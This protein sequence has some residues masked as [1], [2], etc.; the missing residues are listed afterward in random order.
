M[1]N[2]AK[3]TMIL[4]VAGLVLSL[5]VHSASAQQQG[6]FDPQ[7]MARDLPSQPFVGITTDGKPQTGLFGIKPTGVSTAP[8]IE[9]AEAFLAS[10]TAE[11]RAKTLFPIDHTEWR[12]WANVH[13]FKRQGVSLQEM[14]KTQRQSAYD[15]L[16]V[17]LSARGYE[18]SRDIMK[19][20]HHLAELVS[21]FDEYGE[22]LYWFTLMGEPSDKEPWGWQIDGHHLIVNYFVLGDQVVMT[23]TFM[24]SEPVK[25]LSGD[26]AGISIL[27][28]EQQ[29]ALTLMQA[30]PL[31]QQQQALLGDKQGRSENTAE[32]FKDNL[33]L[34]AEGLPAESMGETHRAML[35]DIIRLFVG[36]IGDGHA[37]VKMDEVIAHLDDTHF[38][39]KGGIEADAVF[40]YRIQ[41]P[42]ILVEFDH[43]GPIALDGPRAVPTRR[44][45][46]TVV[47]TPN[48][49]DYGKDLLRQHYADHAHDP[50]HGHR[51]PA[52]Q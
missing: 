49:N 52:A 26:F 24:G 35:L 42:V 7:A 15:L 4:A 43:Q 31:E 38:S 36:N 13:R 37:K 6:G 14:T 39:W 16:K 30:L 34:A 2:H 9:A 1:T 23:P 17:S 20:N 44:H 41:S 29:A 3:H 22:N 25:A 32:M 48:G 47:R 40:Y 10:L 19:L 33:V 12:N 28:P 27:E 51:T 11:Q 45:I 18:T 8:M 50:A 21:N 5:P 46:H